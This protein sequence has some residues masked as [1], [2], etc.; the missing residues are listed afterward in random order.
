VLIVGCNI[1]VTF[2][3]YR[4]RGYVYSLLDAGVM[5]QRLGHLAG[6]LGHHTTLAWDFDDSAVLKSLGQQA[7]EYGVGCLLAL[8]E[9]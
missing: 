4:G 1:G 7:P 2:Q 8:A 5:A 6:A 3:K 9:I